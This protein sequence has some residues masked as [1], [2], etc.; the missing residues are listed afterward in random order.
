[1]TSSKEVEPTVT[2]QIL[3]GDPLVMGLRT[4]GEEVCSHLAPHISALGPQLVDLGFGN[5]GSLLS[6]L[7]FVLDPPA[8]GQL[9]VSLLFLNGRQ[10][11]RK[12]R[13]TS[14]QA[15]RPLVLAGL[16]GIGEPGELGLQIP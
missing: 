10:R 16:W 4:S 1:M 8:P 7:Q 9:C 15:L 3:P 11:G 12:L 6:L 14:T 5:V 2:F 13:K